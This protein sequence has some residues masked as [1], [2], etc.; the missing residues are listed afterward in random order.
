ML[1]PI[2]AATIACLVTTGCYASK[3]A[4]GVTEISS[5]PVP[6]IH[7]YPSTEYDGHTVYLY[8]ERWYFRDGDHWAYY[9]DE[10]GQLQDT[11]RRVIAR[12][13]K[14]HTN[15]REDHREDPA[16]EPRERR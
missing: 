12:S 10:P 2:L 16:P 1:R 5:A 14:R 7:S 6:D 8:Q 9:Q 4:V 11:R 3:T 13:P 15:E